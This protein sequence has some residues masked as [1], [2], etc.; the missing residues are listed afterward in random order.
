[1]SQQEEA[2]TIAEAIVKEIRAKHHDFWI[3][4][5]SHYQDHM[6]R[7]EWKTV[8]YTDLRSVV[9]LYRTTRN[10]ASKAFIGFAIIGIAASIVW[11]AVRGLKI[12]GE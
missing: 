3:D 4:P 10:L 1:M 8:D 11:G 9:L 7:K 12:L 2:K 6:Q 5:E